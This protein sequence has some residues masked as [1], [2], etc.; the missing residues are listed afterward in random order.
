MN[1]L[2]LPTNEGIKEYD[3]I[4]TNKINELV[5]E[6]NV[7]ADTV[8]TNTNEIV[9]LETQL[10]SVNNTLTNDVIKRIDFSGSSPDSFE[11]VVKKAW[12]TIPANVPFIGVLS[13][14]GGVMTVSGMR[15]SDLYGFFELSGYQQAGIIKVRM[16]NGVWSQINIG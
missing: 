3:E 13:R 2:K 4:Q 10:S 5:D 12:H 6:V 8:V 15:T 9:S 1:K 14:S 7:F 11:D 16:S